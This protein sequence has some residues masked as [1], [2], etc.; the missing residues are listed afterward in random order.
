MQQKYYKENIMLDAYIIDFL[1]E[2]E[3]RKQVDVGIPLYIYPPGFDG[4][5]DNPHKSDNTGKKN[6]GYIE[7][8]YEVDLD[9]NKDIFVI[10]M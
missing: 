6:K 4:R 7:V 9:I 2:E 3:E 1:K 5:R 8:D 10:E